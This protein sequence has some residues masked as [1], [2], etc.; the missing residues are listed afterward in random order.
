MK[1]TLRL[2]LKKEWFELTKSGIKT[3]DYREINSYWIKRLMESIIENIEQSDYYFAISSLIDGYTQEQV[4]NIYGVKF[5]H[6]DT[7]ILTL[8]YPKNTD[9]ERIIEFENKGIEI[10]CGKHEWGAEPDKLYFVIKHGK[11]IR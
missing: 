11:R 10:G 3:E 8:G 2:S 6:F 7:T 9:T 4:Y 1:N 5:K